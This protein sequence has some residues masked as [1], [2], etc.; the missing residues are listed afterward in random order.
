MR[1]V[2]EPSVTAGAVRS[3]FPGNRPPEDQLLSDQVYPGWILSL[4]TDGIEVHP[5]AF[6]TV[7]VYAP[8]GRPVTVK[9]APLPAVVT[10][11]G[12]RVMYP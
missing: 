1:P 6:V 12:R 4:Q 9:L 5:D 3:T 8:P 2:V 10:S 11:S 7:K